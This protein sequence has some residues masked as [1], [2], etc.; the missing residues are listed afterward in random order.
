MWT[1]RARATMTHR[2]PAKAVSRFV[3]RRA[4][5]FATASVVEAAASSIRPGRA[6]RARCRAGAELSARRRA[7]PGRR[8]L[9]RRRGRGR[10]GDR[11]PARRPRAAGA[12]THARGAGRR[13]R[14][15]ARRCSSPKWSSSTSPTATGSKARRPSS[16][17]MGLELERF[18]PPRCW[19][20]P[21]RRRS[22]RPTR[23]PARRP[24]RRNRRAWR[25]AQPAR[26]ARP[27]RRDHRLPR[28]GPRR[29]HA[30]GR[31]DER[32]P[33]RN[34]SHPALGPVQ[35]RPPDLG[36]AGH[37]DI[38]K[39]FGRKSSVEGLHA[40]HGNGVSL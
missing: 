23:R 40:A 1:S 18:G 25:A 10:P 3:Q 26:Q 5:A 29:P 34:G 8:H 28:L 16:A 6:R 30:L 32:A 11:R 35:P 36:E 22:A 4:A 21:S 24:R 7:R 37:G 9:H 31:R 33:A 38:E 20:A 39:L 15:R 2:I 14:S 12:R 19:S 17:D 27:R 13:A